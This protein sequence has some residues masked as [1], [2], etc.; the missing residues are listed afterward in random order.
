MRA[1]R[2]ALV[3]TAFTSLACIYGSLRLDID[4][5]R[6]VKEPYE[7]LGGDYTLGYL[8]AH[9]WSRALACAGRSYAFYWKYR[10]LMK[11]VI[12]P[13][14]LRRFEVEER[15]FGYVMPD[16]GEAHTATTYRKRLVVPEP[17]RFFR[18]GA[19][20]PLLTAIL[21]LPTLA[22]TRALTRRGPD[23]LEYQYH[24]NPHPIFIALRLIGIFAGLATILLLYR[25]LREQAGEHVAL[26]GA[27]VMAALPPAVMFFPNLHYDAILTPFLFAAA[28]LFARKRYVLGGA[29][30][31]LALA[32]KNTAVFLGAALLLYLV[33]E[34]WRERGASD[35]ARVA[36][37]F[38]RRIRGLALFSIV[39][40][41]VSSPFASP[42]S[43]VQEVLSPVFHRAHDPRGE[44][45][46]RYQLNAP[47]PGTVVDS[48]AVS[49]ITLIQKVQWVLGYNLSLLFVLLAFPLAW[50]RMN[51]ALGR[52]SL[53]MLAVS[54]PY[55]VVFGDG[56]GYR[57]LMYLPFF[58]VVAALGLERRA[59]IGILVLLLA[60]D[61]VFLM[62]PLFATGMPHG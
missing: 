40:L 3:L 34:A 1:W 59:Q 44:N 52:I 26:R 32:S 33:L 27:A 30:M 57:S 36:D 21:R 22:L 2:L 55:R 7:M 14:D 48:R 15:R 29:S 61:C 54:F 28:V 37:E 62:N 9:E 39:A 60:V 47:V 51:D 17:G 43:Q 42:V 5:F 46:V 10:P 12:A 58:V 49:A 13:G 25:V 24:R 4:E 50:P 31:G 56:M 8:R 16:T 11:P 19:G 23:L 18:N 38:R 41:A 45:A 20:A 6:V 53:C 35:P